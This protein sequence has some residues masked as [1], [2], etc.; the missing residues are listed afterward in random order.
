MKVIFFYLVVILVSCVPL[1]PCELD[2]ASLGH[3]LTKRLIDLQGGPDAFVWDE[4]G[5]LYPQ[6][7]TA[8]MWLKEYRLTGK[9]KYINRSIDSN[10]PLVPRSVKDDRSGSPH[11]IC[12]GRHWRGRKNEGQKNLLIVPVGDG[13]R[14]DFWL[15]RPEDA[16]FDIIAI[17]YGDNPDEFQCPLCAKVYNM[18]GPKWRL[19]YLYTASPEWHAIATQYEYIMLPDD[20]LGM[21]TCT[22]NAVFELMRRY[23]VLLGQPSVCEADKP[24]TWRPELHQRIQYELRFTTF[25]EVMAPV[26]RMDFFDEVVKHTF[27]KVSQRE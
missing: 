17:Y 12:G 27:S 9:W 3:Y 11:E 2:T 13:W 8:V 5:L 10:S 23:D 14:A 20:D 15:D 26:F 6:N 7:Q 25:V 19:Y 22:I 16:I 1:T 4:S 18:K 24:G 21:D